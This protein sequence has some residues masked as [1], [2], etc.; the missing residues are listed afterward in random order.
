MERMLASGS[1][2]NSVRLWDPRLGKQIGEPLKGHTKWITGLAWE[3]VHL[4]V[5]SLSHFLHRQL[6]SEYAETPSSLA[7]HLLARMP[8]SECGIP[9]PAVWISLSAATLRP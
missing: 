7:W 1:M 8:L 4:L 5:G 6:T 2:D 9:K 3:P